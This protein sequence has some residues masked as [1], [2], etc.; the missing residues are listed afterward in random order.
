VWNL[1]AGVLWRVVVLLTNAGLLADDFY[2]PGLATYPVHLLDGPRPV[3]FDGGTTCA[4]RL[5]TDAIRSALGPK[6]PEVLFITH[7]HWDHCG[8]VSY[9]KQVFPSIVI[10][11]SQKAADI[12][13]RQGAVE[14]ITR[15]NKEARASLVALP[16]ADNSR[17]IDE[18]FHPFHIDIHLVDGQVISLGAGLTVEVLATPGHTRDHLSYYIPQKKI[19]IASEASGCLDSAGNIVVQFLYDYEAYLSSLKRISDLPVE[20]LCQGHRIVFMGK[21]EVRSFLASSIKETIRFRDEISRLLDAEY[22]AIDPVV[23][24]IKTEH[25]DTNKGVKQP[26]VP[27]LLNLRAQVAHLSKRRT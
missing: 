14:L 24:K 8:A 25:Y 20:I 12:L 3:L 7:V 17:L 16:E 18:P 6:E 13:K 1:T 22:G 11:A 27:Y 23:R 5:Y 21:E 15:L 10:G 19:L 2:V 26:E 9:L 4:G